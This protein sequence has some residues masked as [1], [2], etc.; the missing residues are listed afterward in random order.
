[1]SDCKIAQCLENYAYGVT[2]L[3]SQIIP[4]IP[5]VNKAFGGNPFAHFCS[6]MNV[7]PGCET[8]GIPC[9]CADWV[10]ELLLATNFL[11]GAATTATIVA[12]IVMYHWTMI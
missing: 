4:S 11:R 12:V 1:M 8:R 2:I 7:P 6:F 9:V 3:A 5:L 10:S